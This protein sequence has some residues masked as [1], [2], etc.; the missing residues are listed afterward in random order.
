MGQFSQIIIAACF[1][2]AVVQLLTQNPEADYYRLHPQL[3]SFTIST[4]DITEL[5][6]MMKNATQTLVYGFADLGFASKFIK[7][8]EGANTGSAH[9]EPLQV[10][11]PKGTKCPVFLINIAIHE[12]TLGSYDEV[13]LAFLVKEDFKKTPPVHCVD[14][15]FACIPQI[16]NMGFSMYYPYIWVG[17]EKGAKL[18]RE[19]MG[20][21]KVQVSP[22][23]AGIDLVKNR[24]TARFGQAVEMDLD[25]APKL[26]EQLQFLVGALKQLGPKELFCSIWEHVVKGRPRVHNFYGSAG[27]PTIANFSNHFPVGVGSLYAREAVIVR[28]NGETDQVRSGILDLSKVEFKGIS[29]FRNSKLTLS[30]PINIGSGPVAV[31]ELN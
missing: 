15:G 2:A 3:S 31:K 1:F 4:G 24:V 23:Q 25:I 20:I 5:P 19:A 18:G 27:V 12:S 21:K 30:P 10:L 16:M 11:T 9:F 29:V 22:A 7:E 6:F 26:G 17:D 13:V 14:D 8:D 28:F